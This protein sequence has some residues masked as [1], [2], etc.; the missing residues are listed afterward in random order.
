MAMGLGKRVSVGAFGTALT[1]G[2]GFGTGVT[3]TNH[4]EATEELKTGVRD[5]TG[6]EDSDLSLQLPFEIEETG[7]PEG[8]E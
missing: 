5:A 2:L 8:S 6:T 7:T 4:P 3:I 1:F